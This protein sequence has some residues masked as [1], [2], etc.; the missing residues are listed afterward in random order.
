MPVLLFGCES[1]Y[2][3]DTALDDLERFQ[4]ESVGKSCVCLTFSPMFLY[5]SDSTGLVFEQEYSL[6]S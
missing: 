3:T 4:C 6:E 1:W 5:E 2:L